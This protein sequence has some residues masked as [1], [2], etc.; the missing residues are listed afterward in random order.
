M[1]LTERH[2]FGLAVTVLFVG[3]QPVIDCVVWF[4]S[5]VC[6]QA[7]V[8]RACCVCLS[9]GAAAAVYDYV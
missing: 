8:A 6:S 9:L 5:P 1:S 2:P 4:P 3:T 7:R